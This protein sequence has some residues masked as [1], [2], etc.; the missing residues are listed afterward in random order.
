MKNVLVLFGGCSSEHDVSVV[1][2]ASVIA[3][4]DAEKYNIYMMGITKDGKWYL[5][6][7][8]VSSLPEDKW[9]NDGKRTKIEMSMVL[10][11]SV[12][13]DQRLFILTSLSLFYMVKTE[14]TAQ[15]R[16]CSN[17]RAFHLSDAI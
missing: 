3:N 10:L 8:P 17:L 9:L 14:R 4:I 16:D 2:A 15:F 11:Y 1:S 13:L 5:Y 7:G 12:K 6:E